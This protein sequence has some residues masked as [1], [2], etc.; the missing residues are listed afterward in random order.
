M[1]TH[2]ETMALKTE[3]L[4]RFFDGQQV[5]DSKIFDLQKV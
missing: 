3:R 5:A 4:V 1:V 2:D